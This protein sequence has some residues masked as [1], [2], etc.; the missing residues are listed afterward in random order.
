MHQRFVGVVAGA[1]IQLRLLQ[2]AATV[3]GTIVYIDHLHAGIEQIDGRQHTVAVQTIGVELV[4]LEVRGGDKSNAVDLHGHQ[5]AVQDHGVGDVSDVKFI[6]TNQ[7]ETLGHAPTQFIQG[8]DGA[9]QLMQFTVHLSH[10]FVEMQAGFTL[11]GNGL[12]KAVHQKAFPSA[13]PTIQINALRNIG[14]VDEFFD[15]VGAFA[16]V[17]SPCLGAIV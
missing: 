7:L 1:Q 8:V 4:G 13:N 14:V 9:L 2:H 17:T 16:F 5:Q 3:V 12:V 6:E 15:G 11:Y 10:E